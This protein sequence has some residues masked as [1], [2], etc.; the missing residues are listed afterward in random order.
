MEAIYMYVLSKYVFCMLV[1]ML[2]C[3]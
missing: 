3:N 2:S 1:L